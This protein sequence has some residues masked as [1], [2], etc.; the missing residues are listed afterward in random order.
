MSNNK[1]RILVVDD[2]AL[3]IEIILGMLEGENYQ[4]DV[5]RDGVEAWALLEGN[6]E[7]YDVVLLDRMM[8]R[9][10]GM[11]V[12]SRIKSHTLL[13]HIPVILQTAMNAREHMVEG[14]RAGAYYYLV[15]PYDGDVL[16]S[17]VRTAA[18]DNRQYRN[19]LKELREATR[20]LGLLHSGC[21]RFRTLAEARALATLLANACPNS[22]SVA[23]GLAEL[24]INAVEHG[25]LGINY[26]E[27]SVLNAAGFWEA[28]V[29]R[30]LALDTLSTRQV[31]V[32]FSRDEDTIRILITDQ[33]EG[34]DW[35]KYL[36]LSPE[37]ALDNHGRGI[38]MAKMLSFSELEYR[39]RGNQVAVTI[40]SRQYGNH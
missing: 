40:S 11:E 6:P 26:Q 25:N 19:I 21:F 36:T 3:N 18:R 37:R 10:D 31:E 12:L 16:V 5:A 2:E 8:P 17:V 15:K 35:E 24:M 4:F 1:S 22:E 20:T 29:E 39:G 30:R 27:K 38:A 33:G 9:M 28:E 13:R 7:A 34:F 14:I 32:E 23:M